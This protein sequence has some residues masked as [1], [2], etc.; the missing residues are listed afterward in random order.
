VIASSQFRVFRRD[1]FKST[2][3]SRVKIRGTAPAR[4][5]RP[6]RVDRP[7]L[8]QSRSIK[9]W[10]PDPIIKRHQFDNPSLL[11]SNLK[12]LKFGLNYPNES[13]FPDFRKW[14]QVR[15]SNIFEHSQ[16]TKIGRFSPRLL[17]KLPPHTQSA[18]TSRGP[19]PALSSQVNVSQLSPPTSNSNLVHLHFERRLP[20]ATLRSRDVR[21]WCFYCQLQSAITLR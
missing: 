12:S 13:D 10:P 6:L 14:S 16:L 3:E 17:V 11:T 1:H 18:V 8:S 20:H 7:L 5:Q 19:S 21:V 4:R 15:Y 2:D 9:I